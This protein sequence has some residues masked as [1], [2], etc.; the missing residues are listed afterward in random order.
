MLHIKEEGR[1]YYCDDNGNRTKVELPFSWFDRN[2]KSQLCYINKDYVIFCI[3]GLKESFVLD[4]NFPERE[5]IR[6]DEVYIEDN[7]QHLHKL[8][9]TKRISVTSYIYRDW[10]RSFQFIVNEKKQVFVIPKCQKKDVIICYR[11][12]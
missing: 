4:R 7:I 1:V 9:N 11:I 6:S 10:I 2:L 5:L 3:K 12:Y 8:W